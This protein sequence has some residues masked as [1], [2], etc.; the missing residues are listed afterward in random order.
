ML[1]VIGVLD[2]SDPD[3]Y[4]TPSSYS[5]GSGDIQSIEDEL[6]EWARRRGW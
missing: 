6:G 5:T 4:S 3:L 1:D 2:R